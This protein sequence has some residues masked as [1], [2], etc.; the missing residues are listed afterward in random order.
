MVFIRRNHTTFQIFYFLS[1]NHCQ[2]VHNVTTVK[3]KAHDS[4]DYYDRRMRSSLIT[5]FY[6]CLYFYLSSDVLFLRNRLYIT[7]GMTSN[8]LQSYRTLLQ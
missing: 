7:A 6:S 1:S 2:S 3:D 8:M 5:L 4:S